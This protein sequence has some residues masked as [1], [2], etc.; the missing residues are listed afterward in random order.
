MMMR[1]VSKGQWIVEV[2]VSVRNKTNQN[3]TK[4]S[5][6]YCFLHFH[7]DHSKLASFPNNNRHILQ[8]TNHLKSHLSL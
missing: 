7:T 1:L 3:S 2:S 6:F 4:I 5:F 8:L